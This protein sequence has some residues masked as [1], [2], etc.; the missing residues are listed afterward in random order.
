MTTK[1]MSAPLAT[2]VCST[3]QWGPGQIGR[4]VALNLFVLACLAMLA[5][6]CATVEPRTLA[7]NRAVD[8]LVED[9]E[10]RWP[11]FAAAQAGNAEAKRV[12]LG[13]ADSGLHTD[14]YVAIHNGARGLTVLARDADQE[15]ALRHIEEQYS[16]NYDQEVAEF[17]SESHAAAA[18]LAEKANLLILMD[19]EDSD[20]GDVFVTLRALDLTHLKSVAVGTGASD[21]RWEKAG[22]GGLTVLRWLV[23][24]FFMI[25]DIGGTSIEHSFE[26]EKKKT[27]FGTI[28]RGILAIVYTPIAIFTSDYGK[29]R[30]WATG[31]AK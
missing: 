27:I 17:D 29:T 1:P 19:R 20:G 9:L 6:G 14:V 15:V 3:R 11:G 28:G 4:S 2:P 26:D 8:D 31:G 24:P 5:V 12:I 10:T 21:G 18:G 13:V 22:R 23:I 16:D 25:A 30:R 7:A